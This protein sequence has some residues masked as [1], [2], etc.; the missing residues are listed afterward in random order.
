MAVTYLPDDHCVVRYVPWARLR[1]DENDNVVGVLGAAFRLRNNEEYL[2][3]TWAEFFSASGCDE[4]L[5]CA[6]R[7]IRASD[8][9]VRPKSGFA[10]GKVGP[11]KA[12]CLAD[13][14]RYKIRVIHERTSDNPGHAALRLWP[15]ENEPLLELLAETDWSTT[16]LNLNVTAECPRGAACPCA[17]HRRIEA[18][19]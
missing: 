8:M 14:K 13:Q 10:V 7:A 1:K 3:A 17:P 5:A 18:P 11:I 6:V 9:D 12:R 2:S 15:R 16:L 4:N 19:R